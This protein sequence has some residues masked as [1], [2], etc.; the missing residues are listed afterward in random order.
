[1]KI[2]LSDKFTYKKLLLFTLPSIA[3]MIFTSIYGVIDGFFVSNYVGKVEFS[4]INFI[5]P[6]IMILGAIGSMLGSGGNALIARYLGE[7]KPQKAN[8]IF[9]L[10]IYLTIGVGLV[11]TVT[12]FVLIEKIASMLGASGEM[13]SSCVLYGRIVL[14]AL[15]FQMLQFE[16]QSFFVTAE[17]PTIGFIVTLVA[18]C[19]N[20]LLDW[21]FVAVFHFGLPGAAI[22]TAMSQLVGGAVPLFYFGRK[23]TSLLKIGKT[24]FNGKALLKA[25][26]NGSSEFLTNISMSLVSMV[27]NARLLVF[28]PENGIAAYGVLMYVS[29]IF[30]ACYIGFSIGTA[31]LIGYNF[32]SG[33]KVEL[34]NLRKKC[35]TVIL[36]FSLVSFLLGEILA[37]PLSLIFVS[38]DQKLLDLTVKAFKIF[39]FSFLFSG[40][41]IFGSSFFTALNDGL[42]SATISFLRTLVFQIACIFILPIF[43]QTDGIWLSLV[44]AEFLASGVFILLYFINKKKYDY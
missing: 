18:G 36:C 37:R 29:F 43:F 34:K 15:P 20:M 42:I 28:E 27:Y 10:F 19:T 21:L 4:A 38:Y 11:I 32:G 9:S 33:N 1:M 39:S 35:L 6:F 31:P 41:P 23:N 8:S 24:E 22:A 17:K 14:L 40:F 13:L 2:Q 16:F 3:M 25:C 12:A 44:V 7:G 5:W 26:T 30:V